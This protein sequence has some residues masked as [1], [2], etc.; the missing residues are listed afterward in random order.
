VAVAVEHGA[1]QQEPVALV[2]VG[3]DR[4]ALR[5]QPQGRLIL[6]VALAVVVQLVQAPRAGQALLLLRMRFH[7]EVELSNRLIE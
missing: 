2:E 7:K 4:L 3:Q 1:A 6:E 5:P